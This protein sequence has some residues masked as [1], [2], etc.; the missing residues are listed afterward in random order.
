[1]DTPQFVFWII[2]LVSIALLALLW[3]GGNRF[4]SDRWEREVEALHQLA[5]LM[6]FTFG[7]VLAKGDSV[8][9]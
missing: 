1:M 9:I 5:L 2:V 3:I 8:S 6:G 7:A 4:L